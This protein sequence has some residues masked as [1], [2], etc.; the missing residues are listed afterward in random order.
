M[1]SA[2]AGSWSGTAPI[3]Y[4]YQWQRCSSSCVNVGVNQ[5]SYTLGG[6][7]V[8]ARMQVVVTASNSAGSAAATSAQ[9]VAVAAQASSGTL[10]VNLASGADDGEVDVNGSQG[11][12]YPP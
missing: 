11:V 12:G 10:T 3:A 7:D 9:T 6:G 4:A 1:L 5:A 8:G 2:S